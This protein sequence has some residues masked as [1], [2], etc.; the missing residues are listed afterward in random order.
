MFNY[1]YYTDVYKG[2]LTEGEFNKNSRMALSFA[3]R[4]TQGRVSTNTNDK[5][6]DAIDICLCELTDRYYQD[7]LFEKQGVIASESLGSWNKS[8]RSD[9]RTAKQRDRDRY[10]IVRRN[11]SMTGL[12]YAALR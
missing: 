6:Q 12:L 2:E 9:N 7:S 1:E 11:L 4:I 8:Y 3:N 10:E 5:I